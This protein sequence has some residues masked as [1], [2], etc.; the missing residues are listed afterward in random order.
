MCACEYAREH[1]FM[2]VGVTRFVYGGHRQPQL[3]GLAFSL[4]LGFLL[5]S[6]SS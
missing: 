4:R 1:V 3:S 6:M 2:S 5:F